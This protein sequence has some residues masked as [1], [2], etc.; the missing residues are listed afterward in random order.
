MQAYGNYLP[1]IH[2]CSF[3]SFQLS[4]C[5]DLLI[6]KIQSECDEDSTIIFIYLPENIFC[7]WLF[8][9][10]TNSVATIFEPQDL[11]VIFDQ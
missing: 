11:V 10:G 3:C 9:N 6:K 2:A 5:A 7:Y 8:W 1:C 4:A